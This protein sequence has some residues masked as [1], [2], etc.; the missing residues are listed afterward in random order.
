[1]DVLISG[2]T[3]LIGGA[4]NRELLPAGDRVTG[5]S[6]S[7]ASGH[8]HWDPENGQLDVTQLEGFDAVVH[9][10]G[11]SIASGRWTAAKKKEILESRVRGTRLLAGGLARLRRRP[12]VFVVASAV[13]YYGHRPGE[14]LDE[15]SA[16]GDGFLA[17]VCRQW[18][19]AADTAREAGIRTVHTRFGMVLSPA[20]GALKPLLRTA[21]LGLAGPIGDGEQTWSWVALE[22]VA[23]ALAHV[24]RTPELEGPVNVAAPNPVPQ[25]EFAAVLG[26]ILGRPAFVPLP[27]L[28]A[29]LALGQM[30]DE[31]LLSSQLVRPT[32]LAAS[33]YRFRWPE[34][35]PALRAML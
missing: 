6:R 1:M 30:A 22:D 13:G 21:R 7:R 25:R 23:G 33:G 12:S 26:R 15:T 19:A 9:L 32:K 11:E 24:M 27:A 34:L 20:G 16:S 31:L 2:V 18:E 29:R 4:L 3:G 8:M 17:Q 5:L 14:E 10:A 28:A 35:E